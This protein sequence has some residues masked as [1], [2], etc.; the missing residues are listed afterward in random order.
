MDASLGTFS[1]ASV[2]DEPIGGE[3]NPMVRFLSTAIIDAIYFHSDPGR[4]DVI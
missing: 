1:L 4:L 2:N 3:W